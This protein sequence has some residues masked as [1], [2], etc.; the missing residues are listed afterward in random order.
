L[1]QKGV[2]RGV[3]EDRCAYGHETGA[4]GQQDTGHVF[5]PIQK[6]VQSIGAVEKPD[7]GIQEC[8]LQCAIDVERPDISGS[9]AIGILKDPQT[10]IVLGEVGL[11]PPEPASAGNVF[12]QMVP[13]RGQKD[14]GTFRRRPKS[15][16]YC[17]GG[18]SGNNH[19]GFQDHRYFHLV[20]PLL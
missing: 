17:R 14:L 20:S 1:G 2:W 13:G 3:Q 8:L 10:E 5:L 16:C 7:A 15:S 9:A 4:A 19:T 12:P 6:N 11:L 18:P